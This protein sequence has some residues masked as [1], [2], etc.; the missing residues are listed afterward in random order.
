MSDDLDQKYLS[1]NT[2][3]MI[4]EVQDELKE[5]PLTLIE[6]FVLWFKVSFAY[7]FYICW[8]RFRR[9]LGW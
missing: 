8:L 7:P 1:Q 3:D 6:V 5:N 9:W 2:R 4:K